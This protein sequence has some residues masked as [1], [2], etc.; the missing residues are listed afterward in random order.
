[1]ACGPQA[2][3]SGPSNLPVN[4]V[5]WYVAFAFCVWD[6]GRLPTEAEWNYTAAGGAEQRAF[7]WSAP[8]SDVTIDAEHAVYGDVAVAAVGSRARYD[9]GRFGQY[10]L[11]GNVREW[12]LDGGDDLSRYT[13]SNGCNDCA[14]LSGGSRVRRGGDFGADAARARSAFR[15]SALPDAAQVWVG[16]RCAR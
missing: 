12:T 11:A 16:V 10:D 6:G 4:C 5:S 7:P 1:L 15:S 3:Y 8:A 2:T 14:D 13:G 9:I